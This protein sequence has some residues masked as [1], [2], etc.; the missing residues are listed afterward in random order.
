MRQSN[1]QEGYNLT[2]TGTLLTFIQFIFVALTGYISQFDSSRP[3]FFLALNRVPIRRWLI[4]VTLFFTINVLNNYA[5][6]FDISVPMHIILRSGGSITTLI[7]G[8][9]WGKRFSRLQIT[10][11][12]LLTVGVII[13]ASSDA[14]S[15]V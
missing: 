2:L 8:Y 3:P 10:S 5:F 14:K 9:L 12:I 4:N 13:A 7:A 15:K 6:G 11:V 1:N